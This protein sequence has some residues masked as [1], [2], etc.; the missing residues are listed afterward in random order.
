MRDHLFKP[1]PIHFKLL[2][3]RFYLVN[4]TLINRKFLNAPPLEIF[5]I[6]PFLPFVLLLPRKLGFS[7]I[8][9]A[10]SNRS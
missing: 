9:G 2:A 6:R 3:L 10:E 5:C 7:S 1:A 4:Y 8:C